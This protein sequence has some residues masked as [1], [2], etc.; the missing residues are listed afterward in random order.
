MSDKEK[1][2]TLGMAIMLAMLLMAAGFFVGYKVKP[3]EKEL[4]FRHDTIVT[5]DTIHV[6]HFVEVE[7]KV[8]QFAEICVTD[9]IIRNDTI[10]AVLPYEQ[11]HYHMDSL[12]DIWVSG[13]EPRLDSANIVQRQR[14]IVER[15][16]E[17]EKAQNNIIGLYTTTNSVGAAYLRSIG[18]FQIGAMYG[19]KYDKSGA[20]MGMI[21]GY[22]F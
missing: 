12:A 6:D 19:Y 13:I 16:V 18:K 5:T 1:I 7:K 20:D 2:T 9:T 14:T 22:K 15:L 10:F 8:I 11:R 4:V 21:V 17:R 3:A